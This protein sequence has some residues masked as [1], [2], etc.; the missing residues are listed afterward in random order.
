MGSKC[1]N[2]CK[3]TL[4]KTVA[5]PPHIP[6]DHTLL[7]DNDFATIYGHATDAVYELCVVDTRRQLMCAISTKEGRIKSGING[8]YNYVNP[9]R[10]CTPP[11]SVVFATP[12]ENPEIGV[13]DNTVVFAA[14]SSGVVTTTSP[15][16]PPP[17]TSC[18][19]CCTLLDD[20]DEIV[21]SD[22]TTGGVKP[23]RLRHTNVY[24]PFHRN[25]A[26]KHCVVPCERMSS[27]VVCT[28]KC[29]RL[30]TFVSTV[31]DDSPR[32][33]NVCAS[34]DNS[35]PA[36]SRDFS[37]P[38]FSND[39]SPPVPSNASIHTGFAPP[40]MAPAFLPSSQNTPRKT[41]SP[42]K[43][44]KTSSANWL[45][46]A[47]GLRKTAARNLAE[48]KLTVKEI[49]A[50]ANTFTFPM[51]KS[52]V[53]TNKQ[54]G[55]WYCL[56]VDGLNPTPVSGMPFFDPFFNQIRVWHCLKDRE[57]AITSYN[58]LVEMRDL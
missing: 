50:R 43:K 46:D 53:Y 24:L 44:K 40:T 18:F 21:T 27:G 22:D 7:Y 51:D 52:G 42:F 17:H 20:I 13:I 14:V 15:L 9:H 25:W 48:S 11:Q 33:E 54:H 37:S 49:A 4:N 39:F 47:G 19:V 55:T 57:Q 34:C 35:V 26:H 56:D 30:N 29:P 31:F 41:T 38:T 1:T 5:T 8:Q 36:F 12:V 58:C 2:S 28:E 6:V 10:S 23:N 32:F 3:T 45:T 16:V